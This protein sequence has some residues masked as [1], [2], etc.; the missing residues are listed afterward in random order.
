MYDTI[1]EQVKTLIAENLGM[2]LDVETMN[3]DTPLDVEGL[4]LDS[5]GFV[6]L[7]MIV[8]QHFDFQFSEVEI[9]LE[10]FKTIGTLST[11]IAS[12]LTASATQ[13]NH[14]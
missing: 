10:N 5:L 7:I 1:C 2:P 12:K 3:Q 13:L 9:N 11:L 4:E 6:E 8:E 14:D